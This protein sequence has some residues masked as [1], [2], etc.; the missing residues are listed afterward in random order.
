MSTVSISMQIYS[1]VWNDWY[2]TESSIQWEILMCINV[3]IQY[4]S[5][6]Q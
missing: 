2:N 4:N 1:N 3:S 6:C 5:I